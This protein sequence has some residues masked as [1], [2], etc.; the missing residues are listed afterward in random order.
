MG[1][2]CDPTVRAT[3]EDGVIDVSQ[4]FYGAFLRAF[5]NVAIEANDPN[6]T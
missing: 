6:A 4:S 2:G 3:V 1:A 5:L